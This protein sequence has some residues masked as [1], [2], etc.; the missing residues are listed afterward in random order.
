MWAVY[1][2]RATSRL[3]R[4]YAPV[5]RYGVLEPRPRGF[6]WVCTRVLGQLLVT[7]TIYGVYDV[8]SMGAAIL[9]SIFIHN[10]SR[11]HALGDE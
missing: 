8:A 6:H 5:L 11:V 7:A 3:A 4:A 1:N 9:H 2:G 10:N